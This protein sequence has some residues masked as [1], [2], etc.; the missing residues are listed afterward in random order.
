MA[1]EKGTGGR[2]KG[3]Q[4]SAMEALDYCLGGE[5]IEV[6]IDLLIETVDSYDDEDFDY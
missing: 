1:S 5:Q 3:E 4:V 6:N 2:D